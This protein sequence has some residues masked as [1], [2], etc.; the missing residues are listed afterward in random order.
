MATIAAKAKISETRRSNRKT[1]DGTYM[2]TEPIFAKGETPKDPQEQDSAWSKAANWYNYYYSMKDYAPYVYKYAT[3]I[4]GWNKNQIALVKGLKDFEV[5]MSPGPGKACVIWARG[6]EY[7]SDWQAKIKVKMDEMLELAI[8]RQTEVVEDVEDDED[9]P[10]KVVITP[11]MRMKYKMMDTIYADFDDHIVEGWFEN[12]Y[13]RKLDVYTLCKKYDIKGQGVIMF[14]ERVM[15]YLSEYS[16]AYNKTCEQCIE[17]FEHVSRG[18]LKK[19]IK[20]LESIINDCDALK[21]SAKAVKIPKAKKPKASDKQVE[22]LKFLKESIEY[23]L[24][25]INPVMIPTQFRLYVFNTKYKKLFEYVT[26][27]TKGFEVKGCT[28]QNFDPKLSRCI[29]LRK[30]EEVLPE[31]LKKSPK[32]IDNLWKTLT[33]KTGECNGRI[34]AECILLRVMDK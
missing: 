19:A 25:S 11:Q 28:L 7:N 32:Q 10:V 20:Q 24:A 21:Q 12:D 4:L 30:P 18:N 29:G 14:K 5:G 34:N 2:G 16:E 23:K 17:A 6:W 8:K 22:N 1:I 31:V 33:T 13:D 15:C 3:E 26:E 9:A 27:S